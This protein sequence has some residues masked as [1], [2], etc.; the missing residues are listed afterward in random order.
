[1][2]TIQLFGRLLEPFRQRGDELFPLGQLRFQCFHA[3]L[4]GSFSPMWKNGNTIA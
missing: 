2:E 1:M 4:H 3:F